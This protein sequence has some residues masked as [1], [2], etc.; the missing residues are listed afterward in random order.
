MSRD[1]SDDHIREVELIFD[2]ETD[3]SAH[4][5][6]SD[7][8][9]SFAENIGTRDHYRS[10][11]TETGENLQGVPHFRQ[12]SHAGDTSSNSIF[13]NVDSVG[14]KDSPSTN[15]GVHFAQENRARGAR[16]DSQMHADTFRE[17]SATDT[18]FAQS[19]PGELRFL[20]GAF[21]SGLL[22]IILG[23]ITVCGAV[24][25][26]ID[27]VSMPLLTSAT[28]ELSSPFATVIAQV[29]MVLFGPIAGVACVGA[30][31]AVLRS[32]GYRLAASA[33]FVSMWV[34]WIAGGFVQTFTYGP[35]P[36]YLSSLAFLSAFT[37]TAQGLGMATLGIR[38]SERS[39]LLLTVA[40]V[41]AVGILGVS[42]A[43][44]VAGMTSIAGA[45]GSILTGVVGAMLGMNVW[46][47]F[48]S[49]ILSYRIRAERLMNSFVRAARAPEQYSR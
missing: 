4:T 35:S 11:T 21:T 17:T 1:T 36:F 22:A 34:A 10:A 40:A 43:F 23:I 28:F 14:G 27:A 6:D 46:N 13:M 33:F 18:S 3:K 49:P 7:T 20:V 39:P 41:G 24:F 29:A 2:D 19:S 8:S 32:R 42:A 9:G 44:L 31:W 5:Q 47:R 30:G 38:S 25:S 15:T 26:R 37:V 48:V 12:R 45:V 16:S